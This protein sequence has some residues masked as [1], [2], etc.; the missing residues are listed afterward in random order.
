[1]A[2]SSDMGDNSGADTASSLYGIPA[3]ND[4]SQGQSNHD[5]GF[6]WT[7]LSQGAEAV[8]T[9]NVSLYCIHKEIGSYFSPFPRFQR[10]FEGT[11][12]GRK[13]ILKQRF[14]KKYRHP[15]LEERL[16]SHRLIQVSTSSQELVTD[17]LGEPQLWL[18]RRLDVYID[19]GV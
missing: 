9:A 17:N 7:L 13:V 19:V 11:F 8:R 5:K 4:T 3:I 12:M 15:I 18:Y 10:L 16:S 6:T 14:T 1:M 2:S